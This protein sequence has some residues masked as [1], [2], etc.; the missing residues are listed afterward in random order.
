M[1]VLKS[2]QE[3]ASM[4]SEMEADFGDAPEVEAD[5]KAE[6][7]VE[8]A[9]DIEYV[10]PEDTLE[11]VTDD[12]EEPDEGR[13]AKKA[14]AKDEKTEKVEKVEKPENKRQVDYGALAAE[15]AEHRKTREA[16]EGQRVREA[17]LSER[18]QIIQE[19]LE[20]Q[21]R[22]ATEPQEEQPVAWEDD[23]STYT[24]RLGDRLAR[25][26]TERQQMADWQRQ[27]ETERRE[28]EA[29][30]GEWNRV[31]GEVQ[32]DWTAA[33]EE[34]P[35]INDA[36]STLRESYLGELKALG[37]NGDA[38]ENEMNRIEADHIIRAH[39]TR[40]PIANIVVSLAKQRAG[41]TPKVAE[42]EVKPNGAEKLQRLAKAQEAAG[43]LSGAGGSSPGSNRMSLE[44][45]DCM[46]PA[47]VR[48]WV[49]KV[50]ATNP[51]GADAALGRMLGL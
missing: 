51:E 31:Y 28:Q 43:T 50:S 19:G 20:Q 21:R 15:R 36:Y 10:G 40:T 1:G 49:K 7:V 24:Q 37:W 13:P 38:L 42:E 2:E 33:V 41:W 46:S 29:R 22:V 8:A 39:N 6:V 18:L 48:A 12:Q 17:R 35:T 5:V 4:A 14:K 27:Q 9:D 45:L 23:P 44:T 30:T 25:L 16:L 47:E 34:D 11:E 3:I 26:E 32:S